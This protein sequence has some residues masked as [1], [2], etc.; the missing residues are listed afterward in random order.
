LDRAG[1][2]ADLVESAQRIDEGRKWLDSDG[3]EHAGRV[4]YKNGLA[5]AL[6]T[7]KEAASHA[8]TDMEIPMRAEYTF[9]TQDLNFCDSSDKRTITSLKK[10]VLEFDEAFLALRV[11]QTPE[12]YKTAEQLFSSRD[13]F[14]YCGMPKDRFHIAC[15][16]DITRLGNN[17]STPSVNLAEKALWKQRIASVKNAQSVY[18]AKQ[19]KALGAA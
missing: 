10:G 2:I 1:L 3:L 15:S 14:R 18:V 9:I 13:D 19:K 12:A 8:E 5:A 16:A 6:A 7:F 17:L 11:L 4:S